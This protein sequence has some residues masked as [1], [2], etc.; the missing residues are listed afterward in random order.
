MPDT[1]CG[2]ARFPGPPENQRAPPSERLSKGQVLLISGEGFGEPL[3]DGLCCLYSVSSL[4]AS[5]DV[6][7]IVLWLLPPKPCRASDNKQRT[8][9]ESGKTVAWGGRPWFS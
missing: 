2:L 6:S 5:E 8:V 9:P 7:F 1:N 3:L 4:D